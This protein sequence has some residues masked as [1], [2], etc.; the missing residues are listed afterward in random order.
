[1]KIETI[2]IISAFRNCITEPKC[3]DCP[4]KECELPHSAKDYVRIPKS[5]AMD[6]NNLII[7]LMNGTEENA[8]WNPCNFF[9]KDKTTGR[10]HRVGDDQHDSVF[11]DMEGELHYYNLQNGDGCSGK[12]GNDEN[13]YEFVPSDSGFILE[14]NCASP[15]LGDEHGN[16]WSV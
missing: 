9:V 13:G 4:R 11:V 12:S 16:T 10:I 2:D 14:E 1:M 8:R 5:L 7:R 15:S 6:V 3:R